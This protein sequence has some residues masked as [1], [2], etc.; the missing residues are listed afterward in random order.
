MDI[1]IE[2]SSVL[3]FH[4]LAGC[5]DYRGGGVVAGLSSGTNRF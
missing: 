4:S 1:D 3:S 5:L 2:F